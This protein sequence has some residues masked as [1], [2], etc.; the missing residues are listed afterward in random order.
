[1]PYSIF[2]K[3]F[4]RLLHLA[5]DVILRNSPLATFQNSAQTLHKF[6]KCLVPFEKNMTKETAT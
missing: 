5:I 6:Y 3:N 4:G 1:M 2:Y